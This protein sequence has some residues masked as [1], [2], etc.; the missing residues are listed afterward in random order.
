MKW[1]KVSYI[2]FCVDEKF[3]LFI[4]AV[5]SEFEILKNTEKKIK[6]NN[7]SVMRIYFFKEWSKESRF[8]L[9]LSNIMMNVK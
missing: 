1:I 4:I 7:V 8:K 9:R 2:R 6:N 5:E 3:L